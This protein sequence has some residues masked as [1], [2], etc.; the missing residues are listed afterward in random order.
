MTNFVQDIRSQIAR[1]FSGGG[2]TVQHRPRYKRRSSFQERDKGS[3]F[4]ARAR[5]TMGMWGRMAARV[6]WIK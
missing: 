6:R 2:M 1:I 5:M 3:D 4:A